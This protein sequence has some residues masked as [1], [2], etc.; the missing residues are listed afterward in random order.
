MRQIDFDELK[1][2]GW[3]DIPGIDGI[4][5]QMKDVHKHTVHTMFI[6]Y[7]HIMNA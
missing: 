7:M 1:D 5:R 4:C 6:L 2:S 3:T